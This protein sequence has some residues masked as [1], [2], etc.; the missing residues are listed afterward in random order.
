L[1][2]TINF[3]NTEVTI[4]WFH[5][6]QLFTRALDDVRRKETADRKLPRDVR[7]ATLKNADGPLTEKQLAAL[8]ELE[9]YGFLTAKA[10]R[11]KEMLRWVR[12]A[13]TARGARWRLTHFIRYLLSMLD[14]NPILD[15]VFK[16]LETVMRH[17]ERILARWFRTLQCASEGL[18]SLFLAAKARARGC[19][20][21]ETFITMIYLIAA[22]I[23]NI[24]NST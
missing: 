3:E 16:A 12:K 4:D 8:A 2:S 23:G 6:V 17:K 9:K 19:R 11:A 15:P 18:N 13:E 5:V 14:K 10:W 1:G 24:V 7:W 22:P 21:N 20:N